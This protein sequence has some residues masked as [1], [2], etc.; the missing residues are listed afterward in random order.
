[1]N[2]IKEL[3]ELCIHDLEEV[4]NDLVNLTENC[5]NILEAD[6]KHVAHTASS[7]LSHFA[8]GV[9]HHTL[10][11]VS[12]TATKNKFGILAVLHLILHAAK[13]QKLDTPTIKKYLHND[14]GLT[15]SESSSAER[16]ILSALSKLQHGDLTGAKCK[17][18]YLDMY[19][20]D[21]D[22]LHKE[23]MTL[24]RKYSKIVKYTE[25]E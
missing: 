10:G 23:V 2:L 9:K 7:F 18:H 24:K 6:E 21:P 20:E 11:N 1:M 14:P 19:N 13:P 16:T 25:K 15:S 8:D 3:N 17:Q 4:T 12:A 5:M 22:K